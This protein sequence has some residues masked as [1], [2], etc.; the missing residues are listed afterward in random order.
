MQRGGGGKGAE[1]ERARPRDERN[2]TTEDYAEHGPDARITTLNSGFALD[3][4][5]YF[6]RE[7]LPRTGPARPKKR[8]P[9]ECTDAV[10]SFSASSAA[11]S[12]L[13]GI[14]FR[15]SSCCASRRPVVQPRRN[16]LP[17]V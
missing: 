5:M 3:G 12:V 9:S 14:A 6:E 1:R 17:N 4:E 2:N 7:M 10:S 11:W 15:S 8:P 16:Q 13:V